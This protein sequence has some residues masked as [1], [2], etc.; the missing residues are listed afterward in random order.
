MADIETLLSPVRNDSPAGDDLNLV[1]GDVTF[2]RID[3]LRREVE[4]EL[5]PEGGAGKEADWAGVIRLCEEALTERTKDLQL[6]AYLTEALA[7]KQGFRGLCDGVGLVRELIIRFWDGLHP[8]LDEGEIVLPLRQRPLDWLGSSSEFMRSLRRAPLVWVDQREMLSWEQKLEAE[9][10]DATRLQ[11]PAKYEVMVQDGK[12]TLEQWQ[13]RIGSAPASNLEEALFVVHE[14]Q[15][16]LAGLSELCSKHFEGEDAPDL[17]G[18]RDLL[19]E[20]G[21]YLEG[22][23]GTGQSASVSGEAQPSESGDSTHRVAVSG[24]PIGSRAEA[25]MRLSEVAEFFRRT[26]PHSP[27][28]YLVQRAVRWGEMSLED[29][30]RD[31]VKSEDVLEQIW[32]TLGIK[33]SKETE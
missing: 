12:M 5:D 17:A 4:P 2:A 31:V 18:L 30:M 11:S 10:A 27:V 25:L 6:A 21:T 1:D 15:T 7:R 3:E 8:G 32:D 14:C 28:S 20:V 9:R 16:E 33:S 24:G 19:E 29:L 23:V 22:R 13:V 26:E